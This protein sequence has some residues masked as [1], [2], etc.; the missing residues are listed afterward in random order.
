MN[1]DNFDEQFFK[2]YEANQKENELRHLGLDAFC[3]TEHELL[4]TIDQ[5]IR[6][7]EQLRDEEIKRLKIE[8]DDHLRALKNIHFARIDEEIRCFKEI[9]ALHKRLAPKEDDKPDD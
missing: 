1:K 8:V 7:R 6:L 9:L 5:F 4:E 2:Q 3:S